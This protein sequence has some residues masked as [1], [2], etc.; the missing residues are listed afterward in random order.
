MLQYACAFRLFSFKIRKKIFGGSLLNFI[1]NLN[2]IGNIFKIWVV[3]KK[4]VSSQTVFV[5]LSSGRPEF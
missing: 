2:I 4:I 1:I 5:A 3:P